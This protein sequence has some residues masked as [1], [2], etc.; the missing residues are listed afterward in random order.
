[1]KAEWISEYDMHTDSAYKCPGCR[2]CYAPV[3]KMDDDKYHCCSCGEEAELDDDMREY[4]GEREETKTEI[5]N[6]DKI[7]WDDK[8]GHHSIGCGGKDCVEV[9][10]KKNPVTLKWQAMGGKCS[11]CGTRFII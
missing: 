2:K 10:Y 9:H 3:F 4:F 7:E 5:Q 6:C 1:M 8:N 11:K